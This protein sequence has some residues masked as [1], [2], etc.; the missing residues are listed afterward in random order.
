MRNPSIAIADGHHAASGHPVAALGAWAAISLRWVMLLLVLVAAGLFGMGL[1]EYVDGNAG[2]WRSGAA[3]FERARELLPLARPTDTTVLPSPPAL[4]TAPSEADWQPI[5]F[6]LEADGTL[7]ASGQIDE[8]AALRL[9][10][11][12]DTYGDRVKRVSLDSPGGALNDAIAMARILRKQRVGTVVETGAVCA[13]SCPLVMAGGVTREAEPGAVIGVHQFYLP[14]G[15][16]ADPARIM[17]DTQLT[18]AHISRH[19]ESMGVDPRLWLHA[20]DTPPQTL[21]YISRQEM[22]KYRLTTARF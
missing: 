22:R 18:T 4:R 20:L 3:A 14:V 17:A 19:L 2:L 16:E 6:T 5:A 11:A 7:L 10:A 13:S 12:F 8:G 1:R 9:Q 21:H 15:A